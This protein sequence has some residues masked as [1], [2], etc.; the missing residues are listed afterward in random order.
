VGPA[1]RPHPE[2]ENHRDF[3]PV[4]LMKT[5]VIYPAD[6]NPPGHSG[7]QLRLDPD[8]ADTSVGE[9]AIEKLLLRSFENAPGRRI[10]ELR[11]VGGR[12]R[13]RLGTASL[14]QCRDITGS[15]VTASV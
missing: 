9:V 11:M 2:N 6:P 8:A 12:E 3:G 1:K 7:Q 5:P 13:I 10:H 4:T 15:A 14:R